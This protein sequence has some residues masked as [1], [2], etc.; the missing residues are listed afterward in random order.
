MPVG[1]DEKKKEEEER[2]ELGVLQG[3]VSNG[4]LQGRPF[5]IYLGRST[6]DC[7]ILVGGEPLLCTKFTLTWDVNEP[8]AKVEFFGWV[9]AKR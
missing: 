7:Q 4:E 8:A 5:T 1:E 6:S 3:R 9:L 2:G